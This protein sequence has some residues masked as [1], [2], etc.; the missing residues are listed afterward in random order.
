[1]IKSVAIKLNL[2]SQF[3]FINN[4]NPHHQV[5]YKMFTLLGMLQSYRFFGMLLWVMLQ[6]KYLNR[7]GGFSSEL[8][9]MLAISSS[10]SS[11]ST[12]RSIWKPQQSTRATPNS[13]RIV[14]DIK[15]VQKT[16]DNIS[17]NLVE[18][19]ILWL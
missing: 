11:P 9:L 12:S 4:Q 5:Q 6:N 8:C 3:Y 7:R 14:L 1:M 16:S 17:I 10:F 13:N 2:F 19:I 18:I 15:N